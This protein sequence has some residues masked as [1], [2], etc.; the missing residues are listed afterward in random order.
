MRGLVV[1]VVLA[2]CATGPSPAEIEAREVGERGL[3]QMRAVADR[4]PAYL[5]LC[6]GQMPTATD[7]A[8]DL[9]ARRAMREDMQAIRYR[10]ER[11]MDAVFDEQ[12]ARRRGGLPLGSAGNPISV[13]PVQ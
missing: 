4:R 5:D 3:A 11:H 2:G 1:L 7:A 9:C 6:R 12:A 8:V 10:T 13:R